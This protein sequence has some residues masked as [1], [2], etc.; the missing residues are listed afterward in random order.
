[1]DELAR[2]PAAY[3]TQSMDLVMIGSER[4]FTRS[5]TIVARLHQLPPLGSSP[6]V[7]VVMTTFESEAYVEAAI[8]SLLQQTYW[9][10]E[11]VVVDD[12]S[13]D[14][15][16]SIVSGI[17]ESDGRVRLLSLGFN[18]GTYFS[19]NVG[20]AFAEGEVI[21]FMDSD[22]LSH[23]ERIAEQLAA[24][25]EPGC[26]VSTCCY[27]KLHD[28][29]RL[30]GQRERRAF[31]SQMVR[32]EVFEV[33]GYFDCVRTSADDEFLRRIK[34]AFGPESH[35]NIHRNLYTARVRGGSLSNHPDNPKF[36]AQT[37]GLSPA[38]RMY[39]DS[40]D[41]WHRRV[42]SHGR[43]VFSPFPQLR[44]PFQVD[45][46]L[47]VE[48]L[49]EAKEES[50][51]AI[52]DARGVD[53]DQVESLLETISDCADRVIVVGGASGD[54]AAWEVP[55]PDPAEG[56]DWY[57]GIQVGRGHVL[58][59]HAGMTYSTPRCL[60]R[61]SLWIELLERSA[62]VGLPMDNAQPMSFQNSLATGTI[63]FHTELLSDEGHVRLDA[64]ALRRAPLVGI[65]ELDSLVRRPLQLVAV[66]GIEQASV[67]CSTEGLSSLESRV[68]AVGAVHPASCLLSERQNEPADAIED[69]SA[70]PEALEVK[71]AR[72]PPFDKNSRRPGVV[73]KARGLLRAGDRVVRILLGM[74]TD[75]EK[76]VLVGGALIST[77]SLIGLA[78]AS[79]PMLGV[80]IA[81]AMIFQ[82]G[83]AAFILRRLRLLIMGPG[84]GGSVRADLLGELATIRR[85]ASRAVV[86]I[87]TEPTRADGLVRMEDVAVAPQPT[88]P[89]AEAFRLHVAPLLMRGNVRAALSTWLSVASASSSADSAESHLVTASLVAIAGSPARAK[90]LLIG[91]PSK[92]HQELRDIAHGVVTGSR[93]PEEAIEELLRYFRYGSASHIDAHP[94]IGTR[95]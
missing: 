56:R 25:R 6:L 17:Q 51:V 15:T 42:E 40:A 83:V 29:G 24:L 37:G 18:R 67:G 68:Q 1:M 26:V 4:R 71:V 92:G 66:P 50:V 46:K 11:V 43:I 5:P 78:L 34:Q 91:R 60:E 44:R 35:R 55:T 31:I 93:A 62:V 2:Q 64:E 87:K 58:L 10:V 77:A 74:W 7:S 95:E 79:Q 88:V 48:R 72:K 12:M 85:L 81:G 52:V 36:S 38:R 57:E 63:A 69:A 32:R 8:R 89:V 90:T 84:G 61:M 73:A 21:T 30:I 39:I 41:E 45:E 82:A 65:S 54:N 13:T 59:L 80:I 28:D 53:R 23:P 20:I 19:K 14:R 86:T 16:R 3:G 27:A 33:I 70:P 94:R 22:D 76:V 9:N 75:T 49:A 47:R